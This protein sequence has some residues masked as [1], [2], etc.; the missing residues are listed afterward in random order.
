MRV[1]PMR[2]DKCSPAARSPPGRVVR[3]EPRPHSAVVNRMMPPTTAAPPRGIPRYNSSSRRSPEASSTTTVPTHRRI[4]KPTRVAPTTLLRIR[5]R[6]R[7]VLYVP[8][9]AIGNDHLPAGLR[10]PLVEGTRLRASPAAEKGRRGLTL[11]TRAGQEAGTRPGYRRH[12][13]GV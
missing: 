10:L 1:P 4:P 6:C 7:E 2:S 11:L 12:E 3:S 9:N 5:L 8:W 13:A